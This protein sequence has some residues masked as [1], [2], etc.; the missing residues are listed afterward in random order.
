[1]LKIPCTLF[2]LH[3]SLLAGQKRHFQRVKRNA[4]AYIWCIFLVWKIYAR[5]V[6]G[7]WSWPKFH[8]NSEPF[9]VSIKVSI[10]NRSTSNTN[11]YPIFIFL[12]RGKNDV[13]M[14]L[15]VKRERF[16]LLR[17]SLLKMHNFPL[18][19]G[20]ARELL[21]VFWTFLIFGKTKKRMDY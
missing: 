13:V 17:T 21:A 4:W 18:F 1:M 9:K 16:P 15:M 10:F 2:F 12:D 7:L 14:N 5:S 20:G 8:F 3:A 11:L 6:I 19:P